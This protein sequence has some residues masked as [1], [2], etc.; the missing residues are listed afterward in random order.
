MVSTSMGLMWVVCLL[1]GCFAPR[2]LALTMCRLDLT[3]LEPGRGW[4]DRQMDGWREG[5]WGSWEAREGRWLDRKGRNKDCQATQTDDD[6]LNWCLGDCCSA[7][8]G[9][10][11]SLVY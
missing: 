3:R 6:L 9:A 10:A 4:T 1:I 7:R 8:Y 11:V 2:G 5:E